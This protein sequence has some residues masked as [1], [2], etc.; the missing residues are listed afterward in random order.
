MDTL[1]D[2]RLISEL[3]TTFKKSLEAQDIDGSIR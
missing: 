1:N 2:S 3:L